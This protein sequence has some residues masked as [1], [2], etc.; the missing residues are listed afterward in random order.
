VQNLAQYTGKWIEGHARHLGLFLADEPTELNGDIYQVDY[1]PLVRDQLFAGMTRLDD[2]YHQMAERVAAKHGL[3]GVNTS[4]KHYPRNAHYLCEIV[5]IAS[6][7]PRREV[8]DSYGRVIGTVDGD[9]YPVPRIVI[10]GVATAYF[11]VVPGQPP[12]LDALNADG[13]VG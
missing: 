4:T 10:R 9:P 3:G 5:G 13:L 8:R 7:T 1:D 2:L 12:S 11:V 6:Y